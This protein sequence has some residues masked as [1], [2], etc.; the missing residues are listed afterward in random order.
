MSANK[1]IQDLVLNQL[2]KEKI[3]L[4]VY[5]NNGVPLKGRITSFDNFTFIMV[6]EGK[7][8]LV[9]KHSVSTIVF[10]KEVNILNL[11][12]NAENINT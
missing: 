11:E 2:R 5:L 7:Q 1:T 4:M 9:Y 10:P 3:E 6:N 8:T 12:P